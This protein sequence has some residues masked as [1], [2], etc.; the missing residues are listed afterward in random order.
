MSAHWM[1]NLANMAE[2]SVPSKASV[3]S[4]LA[5]TATERKQFEHDAWINSSR[6]TI[7]VYSSNSSNQVVRQPE[8][9]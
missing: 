4:E 7:R 3:I 9:K 6:R 5:S 2:P 8:V 1:A